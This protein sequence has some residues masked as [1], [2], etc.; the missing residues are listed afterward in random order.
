MGPTPSR[1]ASLSEGET[2]T[3]KKPSDVRGPSAGVEGV[4]ENPARAPGERPG[5]HG[6]TATWGRGGKTG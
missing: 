2:G 5:G 1:L 3:H 6:G 4:Q